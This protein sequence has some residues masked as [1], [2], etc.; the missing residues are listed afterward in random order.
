MLR[1][2]DVVGV[3]STSILLS[4]AKANSELEY[5]SIPYINGVAEQTGQKGRFNEDLKKIPRIYPW[6]EENFI[7]SQNFK[8][9]RLFLLF[10][11]THLVVLLASSGPSLIESPGGQI[12]PTIF[13]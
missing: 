12:A 7:T 2:A 4:E 11:L 8:T 10:I 6:G 5:L 13:S 3:E 1:N 9:I